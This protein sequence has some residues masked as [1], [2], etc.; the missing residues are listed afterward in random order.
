MYKGS[1]RFLQ[2]RAVHAKDKPSDTQENARELQVIPRR[3]SKALDSGEGVKGKLGKRVKGGFIVY[4]AGCR[5]FC[6]Y[7]EMYYYQ[8]T[9]QKL[10]KIQKKA[11]LYVQVIDINYVDNSVIVSRKRVAKQ[12][13]WTRAKQAFENGVILSGIVKDVQD[14]AALV[15]IGGMT[16]SL[17]LSEVNDRLPANLL[18]S[19][20]KGQEVDCTVIGI[21]EKEQEIALS[22]Q[23]LR[24]EQI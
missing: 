7:S 18:S 23:P 16:G 6:P 24:N 13:A 9:N 20:K 8:L 21:G 11:V 17:H 3:I 10:M 2:R 12:E 19:L 4:I 1:S 5:T 14:C 15:D 22:I